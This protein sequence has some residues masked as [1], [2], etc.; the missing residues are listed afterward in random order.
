M[1]DLSKRRKKRGTVHQKK[2]KKKKKAIDTVITWITVR[3]ADLYNLLLLLLLSC[4]I[5]NCTYISGVI[6]QLLIFL[7]SSLINNAYFKVGNVLPS[8]VST[9]QT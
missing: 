4:W 5:F 1:R 2:K 9:N 7:Y 6:Q 8:S 3:Y